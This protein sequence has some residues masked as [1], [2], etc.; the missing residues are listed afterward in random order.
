M[1]TERVVDG[2]ALVP[3]LTE[4]LASRARPTVLTPHDGEWVRLGGSDDPDRIGATV[5]FATAHG[6]TVVR[7]GPSS[8][9]AE[10]GGGTRVVTSGTAA[11]ASAG[12]GDVLAGMVVALLAQGLG[13]FDAATVAAH[14]H[15]RAGRELGE[16]L[17]AGELADAVGVT[18]TAV[19]EGR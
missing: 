9:V 11:L 1:E 5:D 2:D 10:P 3:E 18:I 15:G 4:A 13:P 12:T 17:V 8:I 14:V 6:V 19:R 7:K 16:G